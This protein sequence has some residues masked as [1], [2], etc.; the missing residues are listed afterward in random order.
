[1]WMM[2]ELSGVPEIRPPLYVRPAGRPCTHTVA[3]SEG[4]TVERKGR[5]T[6]PLSDVA[7]TVGSGQ[8]AIAI[9]VLAEAPQAVV[10]VIVAVPA[11]AG[12]PEI[13]LPARGR[14]AGGSVA[15]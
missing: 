14:P 3:P 2:A 1:M 8:G 15:G 12:V 10:A 6:L 13:T 11:V 9:V 4:V 7:A 5:P